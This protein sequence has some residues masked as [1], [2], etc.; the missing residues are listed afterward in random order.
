MEL[1]DKQEA[2][3]KLRKELNKKINKFCP[4]IN[5][6]CRKDC[7]FFQKAHLEKVGSKYELYKNYCFKLNIEL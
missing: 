1:L 5:A 4:I 6:D 7:V 3:K 2:E